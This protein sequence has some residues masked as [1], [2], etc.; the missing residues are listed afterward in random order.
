M[1]AFQGVYTALITPFRNGK[2]DYDA[3]ERLVEQQAAAGVDGIVPCGTTGESP[4]LSMAEHDE[5][6]ERVVKFARK[7]VPVVAGAGSNCT[8]DAVRLSRH[9]AE[10]GVDGLLHVAPYYNKPTQEGL[11]RHFSEVAN[12]VD[13]PIMLYN[14][15]GRCGV[16]IAHD[17]VRRLREAHRNITAIKHATGGVADAAALM[18]VCDIAL[19][20]GDDPITLP[21]MS[22]GAVGVVSV[23]SNLAPR[24]VRKLTQAALAGDFAAARQVHRRLH[25][26]SRRLLG[27]AVNP[28][29]IKTAMALRGFCGEELRL[30]LCPLDARQR[31]SL[32]SLLAEWDMD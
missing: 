17:T 26:R 11:F 2:V 18:D 28:I 23:V 1:H 9:A 16:E 4:T 29:P 25:E 5:V 20:S 19:L 14:I 10:A 8:A 27:L 7:R 22:L 15:P 12:A 13:L 6:V 24:T 3:L 32:E 30:P 21:L 31:E